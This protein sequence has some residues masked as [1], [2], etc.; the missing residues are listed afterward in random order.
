M[1]TP[2]PVRVP[3]GSCAQRLAGGTVHRRR[4]MRSTHIYDHDGIAGEFSGTIVHTLKRASASR[5]GWFVAAVWLAS[6][7][8]DRPSFGNKGYPQP[9]AHRR[10]T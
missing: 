10:L 2:A 6:V 4:S 7:H 1:A 9:A 8:P 5:C 3:A